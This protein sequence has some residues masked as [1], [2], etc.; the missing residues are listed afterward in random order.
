MD[1]RYYRT[2]LERMDEPGLQRRTDFDS[3]HEA[4]YRES[5]AQLVFAS[6]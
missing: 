3:G 2:L 6:L 4:I 5:R 1:N